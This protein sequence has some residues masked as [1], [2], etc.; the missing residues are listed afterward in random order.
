MQSAVGTVQAHLNSD[1]PSAGEVLVA[2]VCAVL[3]LAPYVGLA[4][5]HRAVPWRCAQRWLGLIPQGV[6]ISPRQFVL[7][8][9]VGRHMLIGHLV[10][11]A[12]HSGVAS[13]IPAVQLM[14][15]VLGTL[16]LTTGCGPW[17]VSPDNDLIG[18]W[19][20]TDSSFADAVGFH[21][22]SAH[23]RMTVMRKPVAADE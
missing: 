19:A 1:M 21:N 4:A 11:T 6:Q 20:V 14:V 16:A 10:L 2:G 8:G 18:W 7:C 5:C 3:T 17:H 13:S 23:R 12:R 9:S 22:R 15:V